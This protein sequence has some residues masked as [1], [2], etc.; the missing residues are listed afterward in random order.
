MPTRRDG[1]RIECGG[2]HRQAQ[3][4]VAEEQIDRDQ[5]DQRDEEG[6]EFVA[7]DVAAEQHRAAGERRREGLDH[8]VEHPAGAAVDDQ[9]QADEHADRGE[10]RRVHHRPH[11]DAFDQQADDEGDHDGEDEGDP[12]GQ[13][14][15]DQGQCD[16]GG[17]RRHLA[18]GEVHVVRRLVDHHQGEGHGGI[19]AAAGNARQDL[20]QHAFHVQRLPS[21]LSLRGAQRRGNPHRVCAPGWGLLRRCAPRN[22]ISTP[23]TNA[24]STRRGGS[25]RPARTP[26]CVRSPADTPARRCPAPDW[27]SAPPA[28][29]TRP[30]PPECDA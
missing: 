12:V 27:R 1:H 9:Q 29:S 6:A 17:E 22:D 2:A 15:I 28:G 16:V 7:G 5:H 20:M 8:V 3:L 10:H 19:D 13:A 24:G 21:H 11:Q 4:G 30:R 14:E 25:P 18:L 23:D 26:R